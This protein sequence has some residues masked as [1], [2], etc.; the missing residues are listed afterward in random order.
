MGVF[1][2]NVL[3]SGIDFDDDKVFEALADLP[4][5]FWRGQGTVALATAIVEAPSAVKAAELVAQEVAARVPSAA[6]LRLDE[7]L[8]GIPDIA[9]RVG[10]TREAVRNWANGTRHAGFPLPRGVIGDGIKVWSWSDVNHWLRENLNLGDSEQFPTA[11]DATLINELFLRAGQREEVAP[12]PTW[13]AIEQVTSASETT[14]ASVASKDREWVGPK[15]ERV[16]TR[17]VY[18]A[19]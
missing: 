5:V 2:L 15:R 4:G 18:A 11:H 10:V 9:G 12:S 7:D 14:S 3:F 16:A 6:P 1:R 17:E 19:A 13:S 8:V